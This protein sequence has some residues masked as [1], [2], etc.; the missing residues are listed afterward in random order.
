MWVPPRCPPA[1]T[2]AG[3]R[4]APGAGHG[5]PL[6][7]SALRLGAGASLRRRLTRRRACP[8]YRRVFGRKIKNS[9]K[10]P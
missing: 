2:A 3:S 8:H 9:P 10:V 1:E 6:L 7:A 5:P 4:P